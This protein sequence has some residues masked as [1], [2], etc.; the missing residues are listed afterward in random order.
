MKN[1]EL[2]IIIDAVNR[3]SKP[4]EEV[5][6]S[7]E[8]MAAGITQSQKAMHALGR[9]S[10]AIERMRTLEAKLS[11]TSSEFSTNSKKVAEL[12]REIANI[13]KPSRKLERQ[14]ERSKK[15]SQ[16][17]RE[18]H[19]Q[20]KEELRN[21]R[22]E[23]RG[24][25]VDTRNLAAAQDAVARKL[26]EGTRKM[27]KMAQVSEELT[28][29]RKRMD[30]TLQRAAGASL[31]AGGMAR[32]GDAATGLI[33][34]PI[35]RMRGIER[36]RG[37]LASLGVKDLDAITNAGMDA[38]RNLAGMDTASFIS[39]AYDIKSGISSL[40]DKGVAA[41]TSNAAWTAKATKG[42]VGQMTSLFA[43][44]YGS[45][46][47]NLYKGASDEE[48]GDIFS[49]S[50]SK[51]VEQ[52]KTDG[53]K[54]QQAIQSMGSGLAASGVSLSNQMTAIGMLQQK[55]EAGVA[56]T[57]VAAL[58]RTAADAQK[59]FEEM[60]IDFKTL[61]E[62]GNLRDLPELLAQAKDVFGDEYTT[63]IGSK[64]KK[65]F[66]SDEAMR[67]FEALWGQEK[68]FR[69]NRLEVER[70]QA[71]GSAFTHQMAK[72]VDNNMDARM[73][74]QEQKWN[75]IKARMGAALIPAL[76]RLMPMMDK[77]TGW[78]EGFVTNHSS[79]STALVAVVGGVG[80]IA[81][82]AAPV[83]TAVAALTTAMATMGYQAKKTRAEMAMEG[84]E[85][86]DGG[87]KK[88]RRRRRRGK[89]G[90]KGVLKRA[91]SLGKR[92]LSGAK[93]LPGRFGT[94][95]RLGKGAGRKLGGGAAVAI[96]ALSIGSTLMDK[97]R[98]TGEKAAGI[99]RDLGGIAG[100]AGGATAGA[101]LG[102]LILPGVGT[103][104]GGLIGGM[105]GGAG[106]DWLGNLLGGVFTKDWGDE[107][108]KKTMIANAK[109]KAAAVAG[110]GVMMAAPAMAGVPD[111]ANIP[112]LTPQHS[113]PQIGQIKK[114]YNLNIQ[115][116]PGEDADALVEKVMAELKRREDEERQGALYDID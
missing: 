1:F 67:F 42:D 106:G 92:S 64:M 71:Q 33:S 22:L 98:S 105:A 59:R 14:F 101:A 55:M 74:I 54:M 48:F 46:K 32:A 5:S 52:F 84:L 100:G 87:G 78:V 6:K 23:L 35:E 63:E 104:I 94:A 13:E 51:S 19:R 89:T 60:G 88:Q 37:E 26:E 34:D 82:V 97:E 11:K 43:T 7:S 2:S 68:A 27:K 50:L 65:A 83:V 29:S 115:Q 53:S 79:V 24:A 39:A 70:A 58:G 45:F 41:M 99:T 75:L 44:A 15:A 47:D 62:K 76:E 91:G 90:R 108:D 3:Y 49:A 17:L 116:L 93:A 81:T 73:A 77:V 111:L 95:L 96:G 61:D 40:D 110:A 56:G 85:G 86:D 114:E 21:M 31:V 113:G 112:T 18:K 28:K 16:A 12:G 9:E 20:Q 38:T 10:K 107:D 109:A 57:A 8:K 80:L 72:D 25:G 103:A 66:G 102:T 4:A 30:R 69:S 36:S